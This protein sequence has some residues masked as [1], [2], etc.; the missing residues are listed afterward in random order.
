[1][2]NI[3]V[4]LKCVLPPSTHPTTPADSDEWSFILAI[5]ILHVLKDFFNVFNEFVMVFD[6]LRKL[7]GAFAYINGCHRV[8]QIHGLE[9]AIEACRRLTPCW[10]I[11]DI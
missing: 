6:E 4:I 10:N 1:M 9:D 5:S 11:G 7:S 8:W 2:E 3:R